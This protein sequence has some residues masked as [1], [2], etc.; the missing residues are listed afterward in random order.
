MEFAQGKIVMALEGGYRLD[1][2]AESSVMCVQVLLEDDP[3]QC[4]V[5]EYTRDS[6]RTV[7]QAVWLSSISSSVHMY[8]SF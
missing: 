5:E 3:F 4:S 7:I 1:I 8:T 6:T 2:V